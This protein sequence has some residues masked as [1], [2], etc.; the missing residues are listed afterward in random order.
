MRRQREH[1]RAAFADLARDDNVAAE[2]A[3]EVARDREPEAGAAVFAV[4][5]AVGLAESFEDEL[6]LMRGDADPGVADDEADAAWTPR[7][8]DLDLALL[9]ELERVRDEVLQDLLDPLRIGRDLLRSV[10][11]DR[12]HEGEV[13]VLRD[14][15]EEAA[16]R[17]DDAGDRHVLRVHV[18]LARLDLAEIEDVV[19][20]REEIVSGRVDRL[21]EADLL[22]GQVAGFVVGE[23]L[24]EDE[25][26]VQR[27]AQLV[28][29]VRE[30]VGLVP[31]GTLEGVGLLDRVLARGLEVDRLFREARVRRRQLFLPLFEAGLGLAHRARLLF[32][33]F[34]RDA[35]LFLL[36]LELL[37]LPLRLFEQP[38]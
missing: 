13:L 32:E 10:G 12:G 18:H 37:G 3:R 20:E 24:R 27:R 36:R 14:R 33:L 28:R 31:A 9:G 19:D 23:E 1:E 5:V 6:V 22:L 29:H 4:A 7:R 21:R 34:V 26:A 8:A 11:V 2:E 35:E 38:R 15:L 25:R 16:H 17:L 30:E